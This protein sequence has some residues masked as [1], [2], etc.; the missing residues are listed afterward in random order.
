[1]AEVFFERQPILDANLQTQ[2]V[3]LC[4]HLPPE[5]IQNDL[6]SAIRLIETVE[7]N[8]GFAKVVAGAPL[9]LALPHALLADAPL[10]EMASPDQLILELPLSMVKDVA[11]LKRLK[12]LRADGTLLALGDYDGSEVADKL[13]PISHWARLE[14]AQLDETTLKSRV[15]RIHQSDAQAVAHPVETSEQFDA[16]RQQGVENFQGLFWQH[17]PAEPGYEPGVN[18]SALQS[19]KQE[20]QRPGTSFEPIGVLLSQVPSLAFKLVHSLN[21]LAQAH[22][23]KLDDLHQA[24]HYTGM[25]HLES[26][27]EEVE[28]L[29]EEQTPPELTIT[30]LT[31]ARFCEQAAFVMHMPDQKDEFFLGGLFS[32]L[33]AYFRQ[34]ESGLLEQMVLADA[35]TR[36]I[37]EGEGLMGQ[38]LGWCRSFERG[39]LPDVS[40]T[41]FENDI[42]Y[43]NRIY[44]AACAWAHRIEQNPAEGLSEP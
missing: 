8:T 27:I 16:L 21:D 19:L 23:L 9:W 29:P 2:A 41:F 10:P 18:H 15:A 30:A 33:E 28:A 26:L 36:A 32:L 6:D 13:L 1:M 40:M 4:L 14:T 43:L 22:N 37:L 31:R 12:T 3:R 17:P 34:P 44:L 11:I 7:Q 35:I 24:L 20:M 5:P 39:Q 42:A 25:G 38:V